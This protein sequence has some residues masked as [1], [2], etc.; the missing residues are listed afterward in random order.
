MTQQPDPNE[1]GKKINQQFEEGDF[2]GW[3]ETLYAGVQRNADMIPWAHSTVHPLFEGWLEK[4][5]LIGNGKRAV[6]IGCGMGD[7][8]EKLAQLGFTVTAFDISP[9][10]IA[11]AKERFPESTV[12]YQVAD[13]F[14]LSPQ[15]HGQFDFA[16][17]IFTVQALPQILRQ[18]AL[19]AIPPL[20]KN[21]G[22]LLFVCW[23]REHHETPQGPPWAISKTELKTLEVHGLTLEHEED[24]L[25][26]DEARR[27]RILYRK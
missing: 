6:V 7:D 18:D 3:F 23:A 19:K 9:S 13:L 15:W 14:D 2:T 1:I 24:F 27:F 12:D 8:A 16:L 17:E 22:Q 21:D 5:E 11:W 25:Q 20:L 4:N 26:N 10:A